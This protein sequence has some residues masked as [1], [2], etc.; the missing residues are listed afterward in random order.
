MK[1]LIHFLAPALAVASPLVAQRQEV[2]SLDTL[3]KGVGKIYFGTIA[4]QGRLEEGENA[5]IIKSR[6]GQVTPEYSMKWI[7]TEPTPNGFIFDQQ[8][9]LVNWAVENDKSIRG[10][11][12]L[13]YRDLPTWVESITD[14]A[15]LTTVIERHVD[16]LVRR[17]KGKIRAWDVVNEIFDDQGGLRD[18]V[19]SRVF[20]DGEFVGIAFRAARAADPDA[21]LYINEY[22]LD[23]ADWNKLKSLVSRVNDWKKNNVPIDG[24]GSQTHLIA[25]KI[26][27]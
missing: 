2:E 6:F 13:W 15:E 3:Y 16:T 9:Y 19:F 23:N 27:F 12:L 1:N 4:E 21:K 8:D 25:G 22:D 20:P 24:I 14:K 26:F 7:E 18:S 17:W 5:A 10:H 11:T